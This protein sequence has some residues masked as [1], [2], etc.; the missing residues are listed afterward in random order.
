LVPDE[1]VDLFAAAWIIACVTQP[2]NALS[3]ITDGIHWGTS[4]FAFLRNAMIAATGGAA[5]A[6]AVFGDSLPA[7]W[8]VTGGWIAVR[9]GLG[10]ARVWPGIGKAPLGRTSGVVGRQKKSG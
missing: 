10:A 2:L 1:A 9:A 7:I 4:D 3:F 5:L 6:L 8:V